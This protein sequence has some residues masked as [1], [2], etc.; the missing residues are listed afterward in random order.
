MDISLIITAGGENFLKGDRVYFATHPHMYIDIESNTDAVVPTVR[1]EI[2]F[3][4]GARVRNFEKN[5]DEAHEI[6]DK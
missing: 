5:I 3:S 6:Y 2:C 4:L 1:K